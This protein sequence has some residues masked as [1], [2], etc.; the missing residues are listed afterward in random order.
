MH[1][2]LKKLRYSIRRILERPRAE[3][4]ILLSELV[5][6]AITAFFVYLFIVFMA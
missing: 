1:F 3:K 2:F 5:L 6:A 4:M